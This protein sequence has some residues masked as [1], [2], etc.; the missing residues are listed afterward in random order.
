MRGLP[1]T[2]FLFRSH[3][4]GVK[5]HVVAKGEH[6]L[7]EQMGHFNFSSKIILDFELEGNLLGLLFLPGTAGKNDE[8]IQP[9]PEELVSLEI[10]L[11]WMAQLTHP[12]CIV[13]RWAGPQPLSP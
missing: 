5:R 2:T 9:R 10:V 4:L 1:G 11:C 12:S 6:T 7:C 3:N 13:G 8:V